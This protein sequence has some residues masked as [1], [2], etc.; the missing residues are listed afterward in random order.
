ML[1]ANIHV[2][3][4]KQCSYIKPVKPN[5]KKSQSTAEIDTN[6]TEI[7][8]DDRSLTSMIR[9]VK[10]K[11]RICCML[12]FAGIEIGILTAW[13]ASDFAALMKSNILKFYILAIEGLGT[14]IFST[15]IG[16]LS[17]KIGPL[18]LFVVSNIALLLLF[19][20][21]LF[22][23]INQKSYI[24]WSILAVILGIGDA[25]YYTTLPQIFPALLGRDPTVFAY[26]RSLQAIG[27]CATFLYYTY[28]D[29]NTRLFIN[30]VFTTLGWV[31]LVCSKL[32]R[33]K[34]T[35][36]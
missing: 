2:V 33:S 19:G 35:H 22:W 4:K 7:D 23:N 10:Q 14:S 12:S 20:F 36:S 26:M 31:F 30:I 6:K 29:Y 18:P 8:N 11:W 28:F 24:V 5:L 15:I 3:L 32:G 17:D 16:K 13:Y 21:L 27:M 25:G 34:L 9:L 1:T